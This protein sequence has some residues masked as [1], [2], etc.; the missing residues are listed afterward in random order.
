MIHDLLKFFSKPTY[1]S[2]VLT[3]LYD[4]DLQLRD[5]NTLQYQGSRCSSSKAGELIH[6]FL[7][8]E[9]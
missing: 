4:R 7:N 2:C 5:V 3:S 6:K 8:F 1:L 9:F